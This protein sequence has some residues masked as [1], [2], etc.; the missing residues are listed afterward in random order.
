MGT[1]QRFFDLHHA[2]DTGWIHITKQ[3]L[4]VTTWEGLFN[5]LFTPNVTV[6]DMFVAR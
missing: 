5:N 6:A 2:L 3:G 4:L 1:G